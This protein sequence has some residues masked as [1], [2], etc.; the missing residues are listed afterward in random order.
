MRLRL[1]LLVALTLAAAAC[2]QRGPL[3]LRDAPPPGIKLP[4]PKPYEPVPYPP[5]AERDAHDKQR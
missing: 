2:G 5:D 1:P 3:Y 4:P